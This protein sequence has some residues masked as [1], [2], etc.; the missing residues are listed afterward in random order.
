[1][2]LVS[3]SGSSTR[4]SAAQQLTDAIGTSN[5]PL[6][7]P[8]VTAGDN[9][10]LSST[11]ALQNLPEIRDPA[12]DR[13]TFD[14]SQYIQTLNSIQGYNKGT[15]VNTIYF[16]QLNE[17][18]NR[19]SNTVDPATMRNSIGAAF[20][21][22][23]NFEIT[24]PEPWDFSYDQTQGGSELKGTAILYP[25]M[26]P[27]VGDV[28]YANVGDGNLGEF[29]V[30]SIRP[31]TWRERR[32]YEISYFLYNFPG[33]IDV[34]P[35][36]DAT[37]QE[38]NF[39]K[40][41][42]LG[43]TAALLTSVQADA[44]T[45]LAAQ[46]TVLARM[47]YRDFYDPLLN[48]F[49]IPHSG[50]AYDPFL[51]KFA[52]LMMTY[53]VVKK[54]AVQ[55]FPAVDDPYENTIWA[56][57]GD[58]LTTDLGLVIPFYRLC[59]YK[60]PNMGVGATTLTNRG[61]LMVD[62]TAYTD[63]Q[64]WLASQPVVTPPA[65]TTGATTTT[66]STGDTTTSSGTTT[67]TATTPTT[68]GTT[69][70]GTSTSA[71]ATTTTSTTTTSTI[72]QPTD[73]MGIGEFPTTTTGTGTG[74]TT[75][76]STGSTTTGTGTGATTGT[77]TSG[78]S[79]SSVTATEIGISSELDLSADPS[80]PSY[81]VPA[82]P[83]QGGVYETITPVVQDII[84]PANGYYAFSEDF[85]DGN[86]PGMTPLE[87]VITAVI[88][89]RSYTDTA[90]VISLISAIKVASPIE[91]FYGIPALLKI[92]DITTSSVGNGAAF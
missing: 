25:G 84:I 75:G 37:V 65:S 19:R 14:T 67:G 27:K 22:I 4:S 77:S 68:T 36:Q 91:K 66:P 61:Y 92:I 72:T 74:T 62:G 78:S 86:L 55:L 35:Q 70:S 45:T 56:A 89:T 9:Q 69:T 2:G 21:R 87:R 43:D 46:R 12:L 34:F 82:D 51:V 47:Y 8:G 58:K 10:V 80:G 26:N 71:S 64:A 73:D 50:K 42:Y 85:Y 54:R 38:V 1:M 6:N 81:L 17:N 3:R 16:Q 15:R 31:T 41:N 30:S 49:V 60:I 88:Q 90:S 79:T 48:S 20:R 32:A 52:N 63:Y 13:L 33:S 76:T 83:I 44:L 7:Q 53:S 39:V 18:W 40:G 59:T 24:I 29:K 23:N 5:V 57:L 28:F 11:D